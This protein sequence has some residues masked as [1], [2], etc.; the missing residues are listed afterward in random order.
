M[1]KFFKKLDEAQA[2]RF[3]QADEER[4]ENNMAFNDPY[5]RCPRCNY[6]CQ[7]SYAEKHGLERCPQCGTD[8]PARVMNLA[9]DPAFENTPKPSLKEALRTEAA[10]RPKRVT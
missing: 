4:R 8:E 5:L 2:A 7:K 9:Y 10:N 1:A 6:T 3:V